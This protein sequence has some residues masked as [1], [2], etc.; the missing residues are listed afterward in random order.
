MA[1][2]RKT[3]AL[4][5]LPMLTLALAL[6]TGAAA[7]LVAPP[8][9]PE[10]EQYYQTVPTSTGQR[11]PD[12]TKKAHDAVR[13]GTIS[14]ATERALRQR[15]PTGEALG[16]A[17]ART[18]PEGASSGGLQAPAL[19]SLGEQGL[20]FAFPFLLLLTAAAGVAFAVSRRRHPSR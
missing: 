8:G 10:A 14:E 16:D 4:A 12:A 5:L 3:T 18:A 20:G 9:L 13:D 7:R 17:V 2:M 11:A 15:G 6:P 19:G 1:S